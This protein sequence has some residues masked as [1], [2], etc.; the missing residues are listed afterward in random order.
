MTE[1]T[2]LNISL[3]LRIE[4]SAAGGACNGDLICAQETRC[5]NSDRHGEQR[6][7]D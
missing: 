6:E 4:I 5:A 1:F 7:V 2:A 3:S